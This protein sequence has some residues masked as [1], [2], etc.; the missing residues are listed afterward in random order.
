MFPSSFH[1]RRSR[2][3]PILHGA[4]RKRIHANCMPGLLKTDEVKTFSIVNW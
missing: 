4:K 2:K 1:G 3:T